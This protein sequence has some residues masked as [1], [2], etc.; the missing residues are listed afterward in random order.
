M[1]PEQLGL[2]EFKAK[3]GPLD[4]PDPPGR[5][6]IPDLLDLK[7]FRVKQGPQGRKD[8]KVPSD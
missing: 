1:K 4:R 7:E 2:K 5:R 3:Q 8:R 6:E